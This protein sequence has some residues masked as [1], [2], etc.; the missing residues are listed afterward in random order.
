MKN[1]KLTQQQRDENYKQLN[2]QRRHE[3]KLQEWSNTYPFDPFKKNIT[4]KDWKKYK[5]ARKQAM[6]QLKS[7]NSV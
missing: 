6:D 3:K 4:G 5:K 1:N 7:L 2:R